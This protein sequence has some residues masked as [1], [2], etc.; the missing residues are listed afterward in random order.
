LPRVIIITH[1]FFP[2]PG[3]IAVYVRE[4]ALALAAAGRK[5]E[6]WCPPAAALANAGKQW[7]FAVTPIAGNRGTQGWNCRWSTARLWRKRARDIREAD[8]WLAEPGAVLTAFYDFLFRLP[9]PGRLTLT[10]HG[11]EIL[12][13]TRAPHR[14]CL[15]KRLLGKADAVSV[16]SRFNAQ[17][18]AERT[19]FDPSKVRLAPGA[20]RSDFTTQPRGDTTQ[21]EA[22]RVRLCIVARIHPRKGQH[23]LLEATALLPEAIRARLCIQLAGRIVDSGYLELLEKLAAA[24]GVPVAFSGEVSDAEL[25]HIYANSDI[26]AL[27]SM[28]LPGSIEGFGLVY[29]EAGAHGLPVLAHDTGG[30]RDAVVADETGLL[31]PPCD[32]K[33]LANALA[34]LVESP[35]LRQRLGENG[36]RH[37]L[38]FS[39]EKSAQALLGIKDEE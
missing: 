13:F 21:D 6:V 17:M 12:N 39:W 8:V 22:S 37:A 27:T 29:L 1:E 5:V 16:L 18:L 19:G 38:S 4:M 20:L 7:A 2:Y 3:G 23:A 15:F 32:R 30:V 35:A 28:P 14:R 9:K 11:S 31:V 36:R 34:R 10:L 26:F 25:P 33:A 24:A